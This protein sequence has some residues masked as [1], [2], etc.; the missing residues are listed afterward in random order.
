MRAMHA[1]AIRAVQ[2]L[3]CVAAFA[4]APALGWG[5]R[6]HQIVG[7]VAETRLGPAAR[8]MVGELIGVLSLATPDVATWADD[9]RDRKT[10]TWHYV[11]ILSPTGRYDPAR[12]CPR[13]D[14]IVARIDWAAAELA[15]AEAPAARM[16]A[17]RWLVHLVADVHQPLHASHVQDR[18]GNEVRVRIGTRR[19]PT[20]LHRVWDSDVVSAIERGRDGVEAGR[21]VAR[22]IAP[23]AAATWAANLEPASWAEES[24][25]EVREIYARLGELPPSRGILQLPKGYPAA[26]RE[27]AERRLAQA[28][29]RLAALLDRVAAERGG[30]TRRR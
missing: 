11:N 3:L 22:R 30:V 28:G 14:C 23:A 5:E 19:Q 10:R 21:V 2:A 8:E 12:D 26:G 29:V 16:A 1:P 27:V 9:H 24:S 25:R 18:G 6:G 4:P 20:D 15:R 17:L 7:A 13:R